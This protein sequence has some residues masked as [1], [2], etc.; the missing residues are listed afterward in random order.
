MTMP[1]SHEI[2]QLLAAWSNG[3]QAATEQLIPLV[4]KQ[5]H[6]LANAGSGQGEQDEA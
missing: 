5:L 4:Y 3:D 6:R 1:S 2:T